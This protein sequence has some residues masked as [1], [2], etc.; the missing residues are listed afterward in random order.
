MADKTFECLLSLSRVSKKRR[1]R[2]VLS[3]GIYLSLKIS[4][5][6]R[7]MYLMTRTLSHCDVVGEARH[8]SS[9]IL[10]VPVVYCFVYIKGMSCGCEVGMTRQSCSTG[11][12]RVR[13][14]ALS[15]CD[16]GEA[17]QSCSSRIFARYLF[18]SQNKSRFV[19][20]L[21]NDPDTASL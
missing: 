12:I 16:V 14:K 3:Q 10:A 18:R 7:L 9:L 11:H 21:L 17:Q 13:S 6:L 2:I 4:H 1:C 5:V 20:N 8:T 15:H 19:I